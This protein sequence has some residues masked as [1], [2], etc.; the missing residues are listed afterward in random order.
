MHHV[1]QT[2]L[3]QFSIFLGLH[4][5]LYPWDFCI[6]EM[7]NWGSFKA[8]KT[9]IMFQKTVWQIFLLIYIAILPN[10]SWYLYLYLSLYLKVIYLFSYIWNAFH[11]MTNFSCNI[12]WFSQWSFQCIIFGCGQR[13][14]RFIASHVERL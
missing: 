5:I 13:V 11:E 12:D 4:N 8:I 10:C 3:V 2:S 9:L 14:S 7:K 6:R 1:P